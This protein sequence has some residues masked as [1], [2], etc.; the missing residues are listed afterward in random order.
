M[1]MNEFLGEWSDKIS[2]V[3]NEIDLHAIEKKFTIKSRRIAR[4]LISV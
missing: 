1:K 4:A 2:K 3:T